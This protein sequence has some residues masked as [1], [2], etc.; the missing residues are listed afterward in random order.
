M[1]FFLQP[2]ET[3]HFPLS[4]DTCE[5]ETCVNLTVGDLCFNGTRSLYDCQEEFKP[6]PEYDPYFYELV[7]FNIS[8]PCPNCRDCEKSKLF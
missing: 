6:I 1:Y 5:K 3:K 8:H 2:G 7:C 4:T